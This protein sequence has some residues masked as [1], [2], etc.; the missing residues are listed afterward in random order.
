MD[1]DSQRG[2]AEHARHLRG[3]SADYERTVGGG[4]GVLVV[5]VDTEAGEEHRL[6]DALHPPFEPAEVVGGHVQL[7]E[8]H[9]QKIG[10]IREDHLG[11]QKG[12]PP[13]LPARALRDVWSSRGAIARRLLVLG[14]RLRPGLPR[15]AQAE[16]RDPRGHG[17][18]GYTEDARGAGDVPLS[19]RQ[20]PIELLSQQISGRLVGG[21]R[22][23]RANRILGRWRL[24]QT[25][26]GG[27]EQRAAGEERRALDA[28]AE[29]ADVA[30]PRVADDSTRGRRRTTSAAGS[31]YSAQDLARKC[32]ARVITSS[33]HSRR[34]GRTQRDHGRFG[35]RDPHEPP[36]SKRAYSGLRL[37]AAMIHTSPRAPSGSRRARAQPALRLRRSSLA[38]KR[39][40][41]VA[42]LVQEQRA[43]MRELEEPRL[44]LARVGEG[45]AL[46]AE[47]LG[48]PARSR[49]W[50]HS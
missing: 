2:G 5:V 3:G 11:A 16:P 14:N 39:K 49:G 38:C 34:G 21:R 47:E 37:V 42:D 30:R 28:V 41:Q 45:A 46:V 40:G 26:A 12:Q 31:P 48:S 32:S 50:R 27:S 25:K 8:P 9:V 33:P 35:D 15:P 10:G 1:S 7:R 23:R 17:V 22:H 6:S 19:L 13:H 44:R 4:D 43:A 20:R 29:L 24:G 36:L 18:S